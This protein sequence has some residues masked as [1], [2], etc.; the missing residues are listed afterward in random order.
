MLNWLKKNIIEPISNA[1]VI[2]REKRPPRPV[3]VKRSGETDE[4]RN[5]RYRRETDRWL[6]FKCGIKK[7][8]LKEK[9]IELT[10]EFDGILRG[11]DAEEFD[12][13][14]KEGLKRPATITPT[15]N[16][17]KANEAIG[18]QIKSAITTDAPEQKFKNDPARSIKG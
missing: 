4:Q 3:F 6:A 8:K 5:A 7:S 14:I 18:K 11:K 2:K 17:D 16:L 1:K 13:K 15:P 9:P 10:S 12:R